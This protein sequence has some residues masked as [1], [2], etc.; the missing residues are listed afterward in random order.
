MKKIILFLALFFS[1]QQVCKA[2]NVW[3]MYPIQAS[4]LYD[5][6]GDNYLYLTTFDS[7]L[8]TWMVDST[9]AYGPYINFNN[10]VGI[11]GYQV[12]YSYYFYFVAYNIN[13]H[14]FILDSA[15]I[16]L[17]NP[18]C[19]QQPSS[20]G[21][22][23]QFYNCDWPN[24]GEVQN[25]FYYDIINNAFSECGFG[26]CDQSGVG[27]TFNANFYEGWFYDYEPGDP[28]SGASDAESFTLFQKGMYGYTLG[29]ISSNSFWAGPL[30]G[31]L[32]EVDYENKYITYYSNDSCG[33]IFYSNIVAQH[34]KNGLA[35]VIDTSK[36]HLASDDTWIDQW[37][38]RDLNEPYDTAKS[39]VI[40]K[41]RVIVFAVNK[42]TMA[43]VYCAAYNTVTHQWVVDSLQSNGVN[44]LA[45]TNGTITWNDSSGTLYT[46]GYADSIGWGNFNTPLKID[47]CV[48][49]YQSLTNGNLVYVRNYTIGT[50]NIQFDFG[51]GY[52]TT[53]KS[54]SHLYKNPNGTYRM[55]SP[56]SFNY[57]ICLYALGQSNCKSVSFTVDTK[58][59]SKQ[60]TNVNI[61]YTG[62]KGVYLIDNGSKKKLQVDVFDL[63][64][65]KIK[66][67]SCENAFQK[68]DLM[69]QAN[70][71]YVVRLASADGLL[72]KSFKLVR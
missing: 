31:I 8:T 72:Q 10:N 32:N 1:L 21:N 36:M 28:F 30:D 44:S 9:P 12:D 61:R 59:L 6:S 63:V 52:T 58:T 16:G 20:Y 18:D 27:I 55:M 56:Q 48:K 14:T 23:V 64:G 46:R 24:C 53:L 25:L 68:F 13:Q 19:P 11:L 50:D 57:N 49:N 7:I 26:Y 15:N 70:G 42:D 69:Q 38:V 40:L 37:V 60:N 39:Q 3:K 5:S 71:I 41:D 47:F 22:Y 33:L 4:L 54:Q 34:S 29:F 67:F 35:F 2:Q 45:I 66:S 43:N 17:S 51:D 65:K 62:E